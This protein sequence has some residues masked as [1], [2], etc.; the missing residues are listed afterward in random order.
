MWS[1]KVT[2]L[3]V[4]GS[5]R[6][7]VVEHINAL[8]CSI[9]IQLVRVETCGCAK[10]YSKDATEIQNIQIGEGD[11]CCGMAILLYMIFLRLFTCPTLLKD[12]F[13]VEFEINVIVIFQDNRLV[14]ENFPIS[15]TRF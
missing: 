9:D 11:I 1:D 8:I 7:M 3:H 6:T 12:N 2:A 4:L 14:Q 15:L 13:K 10:V 5:I